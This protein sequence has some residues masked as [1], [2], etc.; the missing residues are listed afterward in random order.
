MN[1]IGGHNWTN[2]Y[3]ASCVN[4]QFSDQVS[5]AASAPLTPV[6]LPS[7]PQEKVAIDITGPFEK[8]TWDCHYAIVLTDYYSKWTEVAFASTVTTEVI[9][10]FLATVFSREGNP[11]Y[12]VSDNGCQFTSHAFAVFLREREIQHLRSSVYYPKANSAVER[13]NRVLK[14]CIQVK[15][16]ANHGKKL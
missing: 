10:H 8:A 6:E 11:T 9:L 4:C 14:E 15:G 12:L 16:V 5:T 1:C 13:F 7:K 3:T 2:L